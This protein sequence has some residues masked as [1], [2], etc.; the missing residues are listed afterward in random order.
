[1]NGDIEALAKAF[2]DD[3]TANDN[4]TSEYDNYINGMYTSRNNMMTNKV[5][6]FLANN[7]NVL[8]AVGAA[9]VV[10]DDGIIDQLSKDYKVERIK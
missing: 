9:H 10:M 5:K 6:E 1:M 8:V 2:S 3:L 7:Q 4:N